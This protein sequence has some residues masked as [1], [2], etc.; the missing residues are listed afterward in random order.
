[1]QVVKRSTLIKRCSKKTNTTLRKKKEKR[2]KWTRMRVTKRRVKPNKAKKK[3]RERQTKRKMKVWPMNPVRP[4]MPASTLKA[5]K[6]RAVV[7]AG[8]DDD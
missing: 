4:E 7:V 1:L 6:M 8:P 2:T 5:P 3:R